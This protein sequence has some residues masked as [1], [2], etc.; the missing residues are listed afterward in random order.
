MPAKPIPTVL[1]TDIGS[2]IDDT[3]ALVHLLRSPELALEM[4]LTE[5]GEAR[6]RA[7]VAGKLLEIA[8]RTDVEIA[9]GVDQGVMTDEQRH[10]G[11]W[12]EDYELSQYPGKVH[13]QGVQAFIEW[14]KAS[15]EIVNIIAIGPPP[16]LAAAL[17]Q[18]P[19]IAQK[20][21]LYGMFGSFDLGYNGTQPIARETN[22][23]VDVDAFRTV[24]SARWHYAV[25]TPLDTC[26]IV[27]LSG[28]LFHN[29]WCATD[30][31]TIRALLENNCIWAPRVTW[32]KVDYFTTASSTLFDTVAVYMAYSED[33]LEFEEITFTVSDEGYTLRDPQGP[34]TLKV[35]MQWKDKAAYL[36][37]LSRRLL[38]KE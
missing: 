33:W 29:I 6:Y 26:G 16:S 24:A 8:E 1:A 22:V 23:C 38:G 27:S 28:E 19:E 15:D 18:A 34:Y 3:W 20:C 21:R 5:T 30:D 4:V 35:A 7:A 13:R 36:R 2:D 25:I 32:M 9:L 10:Q 37:H 12:V 14:V 31:P 17:R 11:P